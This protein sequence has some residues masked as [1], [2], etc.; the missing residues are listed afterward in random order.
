MKWRKLSWQRRSDGTK[1]RAPVRQSVSSFLGEGSSLPGAGSQEPIHWVSVG[2]FNALVWSRT[3]GFVRTSQR[4]RW[5]NSA[6][7]SRYM[8][9]L[10]RFSNPRLLCLLAF[11]SLFKVN[12]RGLKR[13]QGRIVLAAGRDC[14]CSSLLAYVTANCTC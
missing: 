14:V 5:S 12:L 9:H 7:K 6:P 8:V 1:C 10:I 2:G 13:R 3:E 4:S 11:H